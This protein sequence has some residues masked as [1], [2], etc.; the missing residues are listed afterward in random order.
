MRN[1][2]AEF[3]ARMKTIDAPAITVAAIEAAQALPAE[4]LIQRRY[5]IHKR[6]LPVGIDKVVMYNLPKFD[7][8]RLLEK[9]FK[10]KLFHNDNKDSKTLIYYE[11]I[12]SDATP[13]ERN[14]YFRDEN[15]ITLDGACLEG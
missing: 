6:S 1:F 7:A 9:T 11:M 15:K 13:Q 4:R 14:I 2:L 12:P 8:E 10:T 5:N 3:R